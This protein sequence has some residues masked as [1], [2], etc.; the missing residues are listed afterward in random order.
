MVLLKKELLLAQPHIKRL[1]VGARPNY[2]KLE[3]EL[4][5]QV[6]AL[7][8]KLK[9]VS[10]IMVQ[11]KAVSLAKSPKYILHYSN[12]NNFKWSNKWLNSFLRCNNFSNH[13]KTTIAQK[14]PAELE[15]QWQEFLNFVQ[16]HRIQYDYPLQLMGNMDETPLS[17]DMPSNVTIDNKGNKPISIRTCGYE[18]SCF[19]VVLACLANGTKLLPMIIFKLKNVQRL[20]FPSDKIWQN[21]TPNSENSQLLL[22]SQEIRELTES[23]RIKRPPYNIIAEWIK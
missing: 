16:Y 22:I 18:K 14:L 5:K 19:T 21:H 6:R 13:R 9:P 15:T 12:I 1:N 4:A 3:E 20:E 8:D 10:Y 17:F 7:C 23:G 11:N 2:S